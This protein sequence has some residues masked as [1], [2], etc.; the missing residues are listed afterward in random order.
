MIGR[1]EYARRTDAYFR[2]LKIRTLREL[3]NEN[4]VIP[5]GT[6]MRI[7]CK[8]SGFTLQSGH[9]Q[10]CGVAVLISKVPPEDVEIVDTTLCPCGNAAIESQGGEFCS[11]EC[12]VDASPGGQELK[13]KWQDEF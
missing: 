11:A 9:C 6:I 5:A 4:T 2:N 10:S 3:R 13:Q 12:R 7:T 8:M 1:K